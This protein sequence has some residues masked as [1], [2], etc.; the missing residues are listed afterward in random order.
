M[1]H[2]A[3]VLA[4]FVALSA[5]GHASFDL[6]IAPDASGSSY[7]RYDPINRIALGS[8]TVLGAN[9]VSAVANN[10]VGLYTYTAGIVA[11][12]NSTG[13]RLGYPLYGN[14]SMTYSRDGSTIAAM[15]SSFLSLCTL[16]S[17][18]LPLYTATWAIP[19]G[20][21]ARGVIPYLNSRWMVWGTN[22]SGLMAYLVSDAGTTVV[23]SATLVAAANMSYNGL[24]QGTAVFYGNNVYATIPYRDSTNVH[25]LLNL[26][27][28]LSGITSIGTQPLS[29]FSTASTSTSLSAVAGHV[30]MFVVGADQTSPTLARI[31]EFDA[32]PAFALTQNYTTSAFS[33]PTNGSWRMSNV[34]APEPGTWAALGLGLMGLRRRRRS[35]PG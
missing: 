27:L 18:Y 10:P 9:G 35:Q 16:N 2:R 7:V 19:S 33:P 32:S 21:T 30:G 1:N 8:M 24:G 22:A 20:F 11:M 4:G 34:I 26:G 23:T 14:A 3:Y 25:R 12:H 31:Q 17:S 15:N 29:G 13:E 6:F 5:A 28:S